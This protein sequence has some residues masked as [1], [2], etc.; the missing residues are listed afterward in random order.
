MEETKTMPL[1][2]ASWVLTVLALDM[3]SKE[4][5]RN[6]ILAKVRQVATPFLFEFEKW[7]VVTIG[8]GTGQAI[9]PSVH[10]YAV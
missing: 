4:V 3:L 8:L 6:L 2:Q 10:L 1:R 5:Y 7:R 9:S